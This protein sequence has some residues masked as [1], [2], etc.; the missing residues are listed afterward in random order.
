[1]TVPL[2][3]TTLTPFLSAQIGGEVEL[4]HELVGAANDVLGDAVA[5]AG[6]VN[7]DG[8]PDY[9]VGQPRFDGPLGVDQGKVRVFS[10]ADHS[11]IWG[12]AGTRRGDMS[13]ELVVGVGDLNLDGYDEVAYYSV[14]QNISERNGAVT[15]RNGATGLVLYHWEGAFWKFRFGSAFAPAGDVNNDGHPDIVIGAP[16]ANSNEGWAY[17]RSGADGSLLYDFQTPS[18]DEFGGSVAGPGDL[19]HDGYDDLLIGAPAA[20]VGAM[21]NAGA[22]YAYSGFDGSFLFKIE[23]TNSYDRLGYSMDS[24]GDVNDDGYPDLMVGIPGADPNGLNNAGSAV[25]FSGLD[26]SVLFQVDGLEADANFGKRVLHA[27]DVSGDGVDDS[28]IQSIGTC[29]VI[30][31]ID[32]RFLASITPIASMGDAEDMDGDGVRDLL[33]GY[34]IGGFNAGSVQIRAFRSFLTCSA[35]TVSASAGG[36]LDLSFNFPLTAAGQNYATLVSASGHG[37]FTHGIQIPLTLDSLVMAT[38]S[39]NYPVP[40]H[41][42][43]HGKLDASGNATGSMTI[44]SGLSS[45]LIGSVYHVAAVSYPMG[46]LPTYSSISLPISILP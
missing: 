39:G 28:L 42:G 27:G 8:I 3:L 15:V 19:N 37:P 44:P 9:A 2:L 43:L 22:V 1:M 29:H 21:T 14:N 6:D 34:D 41:N 10:G 12:W 40:V 36:V 18:K 4:V 7:G 46:Q 23:G 20:Q 16:G 5:N 31:G 45:S 17:V 35:T 30:S 25:V 26:Q 24:V 11:K 13:G 33:T 32:R 38:A